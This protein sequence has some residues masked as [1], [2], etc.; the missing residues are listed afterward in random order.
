MK[1]RILANG[2]IFFPGEAESAREL[3]LQFRETEAGAVH[4]VM[5]RLK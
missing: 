3:R 1:R 5:L 4:S 2:F